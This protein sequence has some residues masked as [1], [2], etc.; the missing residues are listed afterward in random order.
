MK[1]EA[2][3]RKVA[4]PYAEALMALAEEQ[5]V[6]EAIAANAETIASTIASSADLA[7]LLASP[8]MPAKF[9]KQVLQRV[10]P[11]LHP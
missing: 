6:L 8:V 9:K 3:N 10:F 4:E 1:T 2:I 11:E 7:Q 5:G